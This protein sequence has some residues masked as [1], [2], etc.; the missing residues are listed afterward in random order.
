[1]EETSTEL[2]PTRAMV[3]LVV[4]ILGSFLVSQLF[5]DELPLTNTTPDQASR[6]SVL[7][8]SIP[9]LNMSLYVTP[10]RVPYF[11]LE[12]ANAFSLLTPKQRVYAHHMNVAGWHGTAVVAQQLSVESLPLLQAFF[13]LFDKLPVKEL[14]AKAVA[15]EEELAKFVEYFALLYSNM[16]N[17]LSF[18]DSKFV[19]ACSRETFEKVFALVPEAS[20]KIAPLVD[21]V[22]SLA[23]NELTLAYPPAGIS[24][25]YSP[26]MLEQDVVFVEEFLKSVRRLPCNTRVLKL[27]DKH[28]EVLVA[29]VTAATTEHEYE[30]ARIVVR[31]G[32]YAEYMARV[33]ASL[34]E[35]RK[36]AANPVQEEMLGHYID[37]FQN[38]DVEVHKKSQIAWVRDKGPDVETN[39]GFIESYR[40]PAGVRCE[41]EGFVAVVN[42]DQSLKY[43]RLVADGE[44]FIRRLPWGEAFEKDTFSQPDFTSLEV[45]G[46]A[47][48]G[49]PSGICIPNYDDVR[50]NDGFKNVYLSNVVGAMNFA[51]K[52][53]HLTDAD[54]EAYKTHFFV[55]MSINV[56]V[57]ELLGHGTGKLLSEDD[58]G[59]KNFDAGLI[60][61]LTGAPV[62]TWY[63]PGETWNGKFGGL[64]LAFEECRAEAVALFLGIEREV[65]EIFGMTTDADR[66]KA[67]QV[68]WVNMVRAGVVGLEFYSPE[69][70][71]WRQAHMRARF[72]IL[73]ILLRQT[74][75]IVKISHE[76]DNLTVTV[77]ADRI[78]TDGKAAIGDLLKH[79]NIYKATA[80]VAAGTAYFQDLTVVSDE[81]VAIRETV[82]KLRKPRKQFVQAHTRLSKDGSDAEL[83]EFEASVDGVIDAFVTRHRE[84]PL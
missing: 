30:G 64:S 20:T 15:D 83:V 82:M 51:E 35:A 9:T 52:L 80:D 24:A 1:M 59:V 63:K 32:D 38:G 46:F 37:H 27:G 68:L 19:P 62:A 26:N 3:T 16:G 60:N 48:S 28:Y 47:S 61:P 36:A 10:R 22:F 41:W 34:Q 72:C 53:N 7:S 4:S 14:R 44:T 31:Q 2:T 79:L 5:E 74:N 73:Q 50:Q 70:A 11:R 57:H 66:F 23:D 56:G 8:P 45:L 84:I 81:F 6:Q 54:W 78:E 40:D 75:S 65:M 69:T 12:V 43:G 67:A 21:K 76:G 77:D 49:I 42:K 33:V 29:S 71:Q 58:V 18:G 13:A 39:I 25:Y 55:A 17:Y